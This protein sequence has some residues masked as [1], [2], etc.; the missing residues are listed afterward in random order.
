VYFSLFFMII[1]IALVFYCNLTPLESKCWQ[2]C[3]LTPKHLKLS[4]TKYLSKLRGFSRNFL[5]L[6]RVWQPRAMQ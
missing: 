6:S 3:S 2:L 5:L 4:F 1:L